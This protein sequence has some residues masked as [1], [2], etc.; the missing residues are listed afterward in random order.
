LDLPPTALTNGFGT[1]RGD[2]RVY[3]TTISESHVFSPNFLNELLVA[4][5]RNPNGQG[6]LA[7]F[8]DWS[9]KLGLPNPF[10]V[11]GWPPRSPPAP[12]RK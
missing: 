7:D 3:T 1:G 9:Q 12:S 11:Q 10:G 4:V 6:T 2:S 8:T 5:N